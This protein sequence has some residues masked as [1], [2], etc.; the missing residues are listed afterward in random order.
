M[1]LR[2]KIEEYYAKKD[3]TLI[4]ESR[5]ESGNLDYAIR[6]SGEHYFL[7][8]Q[9]DTLTKGNTQWFYFKV[10][11]TTKGQTVKFSILN[12]VTSIYKNS[13]SLRK[14]RYIQKE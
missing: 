12:F 5:F 1:D 13:N 3:K 4:F 2:G 14:V 8:M 11:N 10:S 9:N 7:L 6:L